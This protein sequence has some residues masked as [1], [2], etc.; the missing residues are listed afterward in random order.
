MPEIRS[1]NIDVD[2]DIDVEIDEFLDACSSSEIEEVIEWLTDSGYIKPIQV[3]GDVEL[4]YADSEY[5]N[6]ISKLNDTISRLRLSD[7]DLAT[8]KQI[9]D[10]L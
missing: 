2:V 7:E 5:L 8:L 9:A 1:Y 6:T 3:I 10:K 4:P